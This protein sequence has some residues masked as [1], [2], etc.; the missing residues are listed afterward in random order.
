MVPLLLATTAALAGVGAITDEEIARSAAV[1][2]MPDESPAERINQLLAARGLNPNEQ[3][4]LA[5]THPGVVEQ[6][7]ISE[8]RLA[9]DYLYSL[10]GVEL[11]KVREGRTLI[12]PE[13]AL[14]S[15]ELK[16]LGKICEHFGQDP[17][18]LKGI[19][20]GPKDGRIYELEL[21]L[22]GKRKKQTVTY[23]MELAWPATPARNEA[24]RV[25]LTK[26]FGAR[27]SRLSHGVGSLLPLQDGSFEVPLDR[28]WDLMPGTKFG[29]HTPAQQVTL[30]PKVSIDGSQSV[31][32]YATERTR[33]FFRVHQ[34][35]PVQ[36]GTRIRLR[37]QV[38]TNLI[39]LEFQQR[40]SDFYMGLSFIG[41]GGQTLGQTFT[42]SGRMGSHPWELLE[43]IQDVPPGATEVEI[44]LSC[45]ASGT[46]WY[47]A[48]S[49]EVVH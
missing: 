40:R 22:R 30:D 23:S 35:V 47:D 36:A 11:H 42:A 13:R 19:R 34:Q 44:V 48:V 7:V 6:L 3:F 20:F 25:S 9:T 12:R 41:N 27:P 33:Q 1:S 29:H 10:T 43:I 4:V 5:S 49:L 14:S 15:F 39:R 18:K 21:S 17:E 8:H 24:S 26:H 28:H 31:R 32:F 37:S 2:Q 45:G 16:A 38:K 46:A